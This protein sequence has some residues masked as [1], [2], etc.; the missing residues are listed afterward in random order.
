M[1][2]QTIETAPRDGTVVDLWHKN[3][4]R[5]V[6]QWWTDD[7]CWTCLFDD[8]EFTHWIDIPIPDCN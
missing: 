8:S 7:D 5:I 2:W 6:D 1:K 3:G 4:F